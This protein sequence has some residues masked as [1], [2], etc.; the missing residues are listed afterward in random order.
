MAVLFE[1]IKVFSLEKI[2]FDDINFCHT[3]KIFIHTAGAVFRTCNFDTNYVASCCTG[4]PIIFALL[5]S[6]DPS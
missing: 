6:M 4:P 5:E 3:D 1:I 2:I